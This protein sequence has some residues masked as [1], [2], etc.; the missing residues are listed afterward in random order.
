MNIGKRIKALEEAAKGIQTSNKM[1]P[2]TL[3]DYFSEEGLKRI[4]AWSQ[5]P[6]NVREMSRKDNGKKL[7]DFL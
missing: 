6:S 1:S 2:P 4:E 7:E 5:L 3:E